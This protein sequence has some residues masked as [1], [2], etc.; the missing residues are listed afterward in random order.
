MEDS[1]ARLISNDEHSD[2][3]DRF[4]IMGLNMKLRILTVCHCY[5]EEDEVIRIISARKATRSEKEQYEELKR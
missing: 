3:E 1:D 5:R 2:D 4:I